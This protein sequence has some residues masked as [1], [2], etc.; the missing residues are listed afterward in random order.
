MENIERRVKDV[1]SQDAFLTAQMSLDSEYKRVN[2]LKENFVY[3]EP[4]G[5]IFNPKEVKSGCEP[6]AAMHYVPIDQTVMNIVQDSTFMK[7]TE[8][9][10]G[11]KASN[12]LRDIKDGEMYKNNPYFQ[13]NPDA[14]V[15]ILYSDA[16]ELVNPLGA[17][18]GKQKGSL[19][20]K[21][22]YFLY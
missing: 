9:D 5:I 4:K 13:E 18:R 16:V 22:I 17:G 6:K 20:K 10:I 7:V 11:A 12:L 2:Y 3:V 1:T 21:I 19:P 8:M 15:L 14:L